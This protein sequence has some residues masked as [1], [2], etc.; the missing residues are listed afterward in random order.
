[1]RNLMDPAIC[2]TVKRLLDESGVDPAG[3]TLELTESSVMSD[4]ARTISVLEELARLGVKLSIDDFGTGYSSLAYLQRLPVD[5]VKIDK[6]FVLP[7]S[8]DPAAEAIVR[9]IL[10]LA[11]N[12]H[13]RVVAEGVEDR[14]TWELLGRLGC[15]EGQGHFMGSPAAPADLAAL[16]VQ[17][18]QLGL[19]AQQAPT[20]TVNDLWMAASPGS[21]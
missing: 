6:S 2:T 19:A 8:S 3:L 12:M 14:G 20:G 11:R 7:M 17:V 15:H 21:S 5:E 1:M 18:R 9:S 4:T 10:D 16:L 13:L